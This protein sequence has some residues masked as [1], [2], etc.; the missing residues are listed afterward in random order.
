MVESIHRKE[1]NNAVRDPSIF[2]LVPTFGLH[3][4]GVLIFS[5][6]KKKYSSLTPN[7]LTVSM[8][9]SSDVGLS[10]NFSLIDLFLRYSALL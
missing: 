5:K 1:T 8:L 6:F 4:F 10:G 9:C 7:V 3:Y 2:I